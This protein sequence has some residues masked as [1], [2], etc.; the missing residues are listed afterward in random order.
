[1]PGAVIEQVPRWLRWTV[2]FPV[3]V[4][5]GFLAAG[6]L[7]SLYPAGAGGSSGALVYSSAFLSG[8]VYAWVAL[9]TAHVV[10]PAHKGIVVAVL[11]FFILGDLSL[12]HLVQTDS[13]SPLTASEVRESEFGVIWRLLRADDT[14]GLPNGTLVKAAGALVGLGLTWLTRGA[15]RLRE[16]KGL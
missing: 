12:V 5:A 15:G 10:A 3:S 7:G 13:L 2:L 9:C 8:L 4:I 6:V 1:M 16:P 14:A 11:G